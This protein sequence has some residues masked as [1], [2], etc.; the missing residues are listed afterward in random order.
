[1]RRDFRLFP[2]S[3]RYVRQPEVLRHLRKLMR[4]YISCWGDGQHIQML[5]CLW[6][7][8]VF[9]DEFIEVVDRSWL[10]FFL[11]GF[12]APGGQ[13]RRMWKIG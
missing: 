6:R 12:A 5:F 2:T 4:Q 3:L 10:S 11:M 13:T 8:A 9:T 1:M 7:T